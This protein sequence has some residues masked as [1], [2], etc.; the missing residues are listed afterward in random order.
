VAE[1]AAAGLMRMLMGDYARTG[2]MGGWLGSFF[3]PQAHSGGR[4]G[5]LTTGRSVSPLAFAGAPRFHSGAALGLRADEVPAI[6]QTGEVVLSRDQVAA[7]GAAKG[8]KVV[9]ENHGTP[10]EATDA[11]VTFDP[12]GLVVTVVTDDLQRGGP[13]SSGISRTFGLRRSG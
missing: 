3:A 5:S 12:N 7:A 2:Q 8:V 1:I 13:I 10:T 6:L 11:Q 4:A 9:I